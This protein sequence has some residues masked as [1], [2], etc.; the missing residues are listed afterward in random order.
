MSERSK[1]TRKSIDARLASNTD[2]ITYAQRAQTLARRLGREKWTAS[3]EKS[4]EKEAKS[5]AN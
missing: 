5:S 2:A 3:C 1:D 4:T